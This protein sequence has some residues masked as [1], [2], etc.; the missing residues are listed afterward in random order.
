LS[1]R[2][3]TAVTGIIRTRWPAGQALIATRAGPDGTIWTS[4]AVGDQAGMRRTGSMT[5]PA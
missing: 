5:A 4:C 1:R 2:R 3:P